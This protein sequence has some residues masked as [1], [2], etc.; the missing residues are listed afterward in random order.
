MRRRVSGTYRP[1]WRPWGIAGGFWPEI[2]KAKTSTPLDNSR[3]GLPEAT[4]SRLAAVRA[5]AERAGT[6][7]PRAV[8]AVGGFSGDPAA[9]SVKLIQSGGGGSG[10]GALA[11]D[12]PQNKHAKV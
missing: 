8:Q 10:V 1:W 9:A 3:A 7:L 4:S 5:A 12:R 11:E 6:R 2:P